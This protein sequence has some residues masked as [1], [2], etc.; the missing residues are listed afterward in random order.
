[1]DKRKE[2]WVFL[3]HY[4]LA[5]CSIFGSCYFSS[6]LKLL[7]GISPYKVL[8]HTGLWELFLLLVSLFQRIVMTSYCVQ[9]LGNKPSLVCF[10]NLAHASVTSSFTLKISSFN[11]SGLDSVFY[12]VFTDTHRTQTHKHTNTFTPK[13]R[14]ISSILYNVILKY[15]NIPT[16]H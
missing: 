6:W 5:W 3:S 12:Q 4:S 11:S 13:L 15:I 10:L 1:M 8:A 2:V 9:F 14:K 7:L 16:K